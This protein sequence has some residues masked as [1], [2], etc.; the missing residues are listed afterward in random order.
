MGVYKCPSRFPRSV[1][2]AAKDF[3]QLSDFVCDLDNRDGDHLAR[4]LAPLF[5]QPLARVI[6]LF[7][8]VIQ[9]VWRRFERVIITRAAEIRANLSGRFLDLAQFLLD[10]AWKMAASSHFRKVLGF[11]LD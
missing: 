4:S 8:R 7:Q 6:E 9:V 3:D 2:I 10:R 11:E 1:Q 5:V